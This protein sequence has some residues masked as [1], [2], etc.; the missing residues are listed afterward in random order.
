M[1]FRFFADT[2]ETERL[3]TL[4]VWSQF[5]DSDLEFRPEPRA[6]KPREHFVH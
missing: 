6:R 4:A 3:K 5:T 1:S 2:Y